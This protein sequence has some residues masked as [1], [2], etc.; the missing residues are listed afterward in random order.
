MVPAL[1]R[2]A[3]AGLRPARA[4]DAA[5]IAGVHVAVWREAYA[6]LVPDGFLARFAARRVERWTGHLTA[7]DAVTV[8]AE[9]ARSIRAP[10]SRRSDSCG[11]A[12]PT[13]R[14]ARRSR[15]LRCTTAAER[16]AWSP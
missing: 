15:S 16:R 4:G 11:S 12:G 8:V 7:A 2:P 5:G 1:G 10:A 6:G 13:P 14:P 9:A 3:L